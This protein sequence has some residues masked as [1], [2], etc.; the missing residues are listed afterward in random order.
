MKRRLLN[1]FAVG[2]SIIPA[3][4]ISCGTNTTSPK[5][6]NPTINEDTQ[7]PVIKAYVPGELMPGVKYDVETYDIIKKEQLKFNVTIDAKGSVTLE[8]DWMRFYVPA[9]A[10][11]I[12]GG[13]ENI[14][15]IFTAVIDN[16]TVTNIAKMNKFQFQFQTSQYS[17][18]ASGA[19]NHDQIANVFLYD[20]YKQKK[21]EELLSYLTAVI[22]HEK[23]M[24]EIRYPVS[25]DNQKIYEA[26]ILKSRWN[27]FVQDPDLPEA[28]KK[29]LQQLELLNLPTSPSSVSG[30]LDSF[31]DYWTNSKS[32]NIF[33]FFY[34]IGDLM[35]ASVWAGSGPYF[36]FITRLESMYTLKFS[37]DLK[38]APYNGDARQLAAVLGYS[39]FARNEEEQSVKIIRS[40]L[41][42]FNLFGQKATAGI[43]VEKRS[44]GDYKTNVWF[45]SIASPD[46][47]SFEKMR[48]T[49]TDTGKYL[50]MPI[51]HKQVPI[52]FNKN[53]FTP[54]EYKYVAD[55]A[56]GNENN[57]KTK[58][59]NVEK[60]KLKV[61]VFDNS[62]NKVD[63]SKINKVVLEE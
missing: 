23:N 25:V 43:Q 34:D 58:V 16:S 45:Y 17:V 22:I 63:D 27:D 52:G 55:S 50:E 62:G 49:N 42:H 24:M 35:T 18:H 40:I 59:L 51:K 2:A 7:A 11:A 48:V 46:T 57:D 32:S 36:E 5:V 54:Y 3:T 26:G 1:S 12:I 8:N 4:L 30:V 10:V 39:F 19:L 60:E 13:V 28:F 14:K 31:T 37:D 33:T 6:A 38:F 41:K 56:Y 20:S 47:N 44:S 9:D 21:P 15:E 53:P 29:A 61:E